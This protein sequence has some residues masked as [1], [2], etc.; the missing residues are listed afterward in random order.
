MACGVDNNL[1]QLALKAGSGTVDFSSGATRLE[2][3]NESLQS[4]GSLLRGEGIRGTR[5]KTVSQARRGPYSVGGAVN[6]DASLNLIKTWG[7]YALGDETTN[8]LTPT[9]TLPVFGLIVDKVSDVCKFEGCKVNRLALTAS[10]GGI[11]KGTADILGLSYSNSALTFPSLTLG[12]TANDYPL[13]LSDAVLTIGGTAYDMS[14]FN[15]TIDNAITSIQRNSLYPGCVRES[16]RSVTLQANI[17][18]TS[19]AWT[20]LDEP[21]LTGVAITLVL[22]STIAAVSASVSLPVCQRARSIPVIAGKGEQTWDIA[23]DCVADSDDDEITI[24][25]DTTV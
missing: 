12:E 23:F 25:L 3:N 1:G 20:A 9:E 22:T 16:Q 4:A 18:S 8:V 5:S 17:P 19:A 10:S 2:F 24:T 6:F 15:L 13:V 11:V 7:E 14:S 21:A